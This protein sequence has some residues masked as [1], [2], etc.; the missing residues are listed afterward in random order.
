MTTG[1]LN[2]GAGHRPVWDGPSDVTIGPADG[3][4]ASA[5]GI[6]DRPHPPQKPKPDGY[7]KPQK[8]D[9]PVEPDRDQEWPDPEGPKPERLLEEYPSGRLPGAREKDRYTPYIVLRYAA[10]DLGARPLP[11]GTTFWHSPDVWVVSSA[12]YNVP[13]AGEENNLFARVN[14][15]GM[16]DAAGVVVRYWWANP[17][18]AITE[19]TAHLID[20]ATTFV[21]SG[22]SVV[23]ACPTPW[24]P[25]VENGGHECVFAEA[26][27]PYYDPI[28][29]PLEP[30]TDRHV[31]QKNLNVVEAAPGA[32]ISFPI[33]VANISAVAQRVTVQLRALS[34]REIEAAL[35]SP[36]IDYREKLLESR[37][38]LPMRMELSPEGEFLA[39]PTS[40]YPLRL[41]AATGMIPREEAMDCQPLGQVTQTSPLEAWESRTLTLHARIPSDSRPH[42]TFAF[43]IQQRMG[44]VVTGGYRLYIVV[45]AEADRA[46]AG[47]S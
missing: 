18:L 16:K 11:P 13:V 40:I 43:D 39:S 10:A 41:L 20:M 30:V 22:G 5:Q 45:A 38:G 15:W 6:D 32:M 12:G 1:N 17:S 27:V 7:D 9:Q 46:D 2:K 33:H 25:I 47:E 26:W 29:A 28:S 4:A 14:N 23:V 37:Q 3:E 42:Q 34:F 24:V 8:P 19:S 35:T 44:E 31:C 21:P 36:D